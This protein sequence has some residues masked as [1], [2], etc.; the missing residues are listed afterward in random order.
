MYK[1]V[2]RHHAIGIRK[3]NVFAVRSSYAY[4]Y[5]KCGVK[6]IGVAD[7]FYGCWRNFDE[8]DEIR[9]IWAQL[10]YAGNRLITTPVYEHNLYVV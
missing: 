10:N 2:T 6:V 3:H 5:G 4:V 1:R 7:R 8:P 9:C